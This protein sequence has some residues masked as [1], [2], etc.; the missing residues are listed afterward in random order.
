MQSA[1]NL[2][3][4]LL[5]ILVSCTKE[6]PENNKKIAKSTEEVSAVSTINGFIDA[7]NQ[8]D[9][10]LASTF[11]DIDY[12]G[13]VADSDDTINARSTIDELKQYRKQYPGGKWEI[14]IEEIYISGEFAYTMTKA[15]FFTPGPVIGSVNP[16]YS[17]RGIRILK[18]QKDDGWKIFRYIAT[19]IFSYDTK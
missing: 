2:F 7:Y 8:N 5:I 1:K 13:V 15:S 12:K 16:I 9:I 11:L 19:P 3:L 18:R 10:A 6:V 14:E 4:F 17:E